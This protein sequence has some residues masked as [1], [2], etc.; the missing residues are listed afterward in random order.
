MKKGSIG[1]AN[2][3]TGLHFEK[4]V[5]LSSALNKIPG[6]EVKGDNI[7]YNKEKI[8]VLYGKNKF[9]KNFLEPQNVDY[10][11]YISYKMFPDEALY[12]IKQKKFYIIEIK[13]QQVSGSVDEKLQSCDFKKKQYLKL[14]SSIDV[15]VEFGY[16]LNDWYEQYKYK[17]VLEY[18]NSVGCFYYFS[19]IPFD[20]LGIP[21]VKMND[22]I[23]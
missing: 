18:I 4:K 19:K 8:A 14:L 22:N 9:Y 2:T 23:I 6:Y 13:F 20:F 5:N 16:I 1:G 12:N 21:E 17:D 15:E 10:G 3:I 11:N 7:Y